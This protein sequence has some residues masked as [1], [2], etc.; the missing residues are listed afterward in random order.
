[1]TGPDFLLAVVGFILIWCAISIPA[2]FI[3]GAWMH[4]CGHPRDHARDE[5]A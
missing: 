1:M 5:D 4:G 3:T 2:C